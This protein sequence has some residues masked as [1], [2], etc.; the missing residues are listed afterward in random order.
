MQFL[1]EQAWGS[2]LKR[3]RQVRKGSFSMH[4]KAQ[5]LRGPRSSLALLLLIDRVEGNIL[6]IV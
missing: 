4:L 3:V 5:K 2:H 1:R 6:Q